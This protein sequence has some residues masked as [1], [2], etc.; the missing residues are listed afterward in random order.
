MLLVDPYWANPQ[1][2]KI[3]PYSFTAE[4]CRDLRDIGPP[5]QRHL[6]PSLQWFE[7]TFS[8][9]STLPMGSVWWL[10]V[11]AEAVGKLIVVDA[12]ISMDAFPTY[13]WMSNGAWCD[14]VQ[15]VLTQV[16]SKH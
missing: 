10:I 15:A 4:L 1:L 5:G 2:S 3:T 16:S 6:V 12:H 13:S 11:D 7:G 14:D 9:P 8:D